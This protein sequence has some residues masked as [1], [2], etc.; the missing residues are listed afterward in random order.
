MFRQ[1][2]T[3]GTAVILNISGSR[4][5]TCCPPSQAF[6][7]VLCSSFYRKMTSISNETAATAA[8]IQTSLASA[9][10]TVASTISSSSSSVAFDGS[11]KGADWLATEWKHSRSEL[12][13]LYVWDSKIEILA[14]LQGYFSSSSFV[15][16]KPSV[17]LFDTM[18]ALLH[19]TLKGKKD[20]NSSQKI[21]AVPELGL[22]Q[23]GVKWPSSAQCPTV[24][25]HSAVLFLILTFPSLSPV[26]SS[27]QV[28][29]TDAGCVGMMGNVNWRKKRKGKKK[30]GCPCVVVA[31]A[32]S[33]CRADCLHCPQEVQQEAAEQRPAGR[34]KVTVR[35]E[36]N[37]FP[38]GCG[39]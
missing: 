28:V 19:F 9:N 21:T 5:K 18:T 8:S 34:A 35:Q 24:S 3:R 14:A 2:H 7:A 4:A 23:W 29:N 11:L 1:Y 22:H 12:G 10:P 30:R 38:L 6:N 39:Y 31:G 26:A 13:K 37:N 36:L 33:L 25:L 15:N 16:F 27:S 20:W 32:V 17:S